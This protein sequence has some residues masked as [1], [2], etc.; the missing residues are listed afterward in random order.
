MATCEDLQIIKNRVH[1]IDLAFKSLK[2]DL[3]K[4]LKERKQLELDL[5]GK[6]TPVPV[7]VTNKFNHDYCDRFW[8]KRIKLL[9]GDG[10]EDLIILYDLNLETWI[11][12]DDIPKEDFIS[13]LSYIKW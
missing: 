7:F 13:L 11:Q 3:I 6:D 2:K 8:I 12:S 10:I 9:Y 5:D 1:K 4:I